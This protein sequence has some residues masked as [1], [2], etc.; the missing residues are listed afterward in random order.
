MQFVAITHFTERDVG[1]TVLV[2]RM[3]KKVAKRMASSMNRAVDFVAKLRAKNKKKRD[4]VPKKVPRPVDRKGAT[5]AA[6]AYRKSANRAASQGN[7]DLSK[8]YK[9]KSR[10]YQRRSW[11]DKVVKRGSNSP[12]PYDLV[13]LRQKRTARR[14]NERWVAIPNFLEAHNRA[15]RLKALQMVRRPKS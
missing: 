9:F 1:T 12:A 11:A 6:W 3:A 5:K 8:K 7:T 4:A 2:R 10:V 13:A 15:G 14:K